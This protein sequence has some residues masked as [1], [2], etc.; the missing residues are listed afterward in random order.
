MLTETRGEFAAWQPY[1]SRTALRFMSSATDGRM[2]PFLSNSVEMICNQ[3]FKN[4][5]RESQCL[6]S[7][8][9]LVALAGLCHK[10][11]F[12]EGSR[13]L[14]PFDL[15]AAGGAKACWRC[16]DAEMS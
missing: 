1:P 6:D 3:N 12:P 10:P 13:M 4:C 9:A 14:T 11:T 16:P 2:H 8:A 5:F 15:S 7:R